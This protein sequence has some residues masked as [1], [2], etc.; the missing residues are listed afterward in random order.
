VSVDDV[1]L[2]QP[3]LDDVFFVLTGR[4]AESGDAADAAGNGEDGQA[5]AGPGAGQQRRAFGGSAAEPERDPESR[6]GSDLQ[7]VPI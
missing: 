5:A 4:P 1:E 2:R 7:E 6:P 3:S